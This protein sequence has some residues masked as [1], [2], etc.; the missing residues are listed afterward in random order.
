MT[1]VPSAGPSRSATSRLFELIR[2]PALVGERLAAEQIRL[3]GGSGWIVHQN[4]KNFPANVGAL[5]VVPRVLGRSRAVSDEDQLTA[6]GAG[7]GR[8]A[9]PDDDIVRKAEIGV[10]LA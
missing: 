7:V 6:R 3:G 5:E 1:A 2:Q 4:E 9:R 10:G 8:R